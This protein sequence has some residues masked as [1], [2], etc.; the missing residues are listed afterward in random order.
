MKIGSIS[1]VIPTMERPIALERTIRNMLKSSVVPK[2]I[3]VIDQS[4]RQENR[5]ANIELKKIFPSEI[6]FIYE[7][8]T[9]PSLTSARNRGLALATEEIVVYSDDDIDVDMVT[10]E[11]ILIE[12]QDQTIAMIAGLDHE[13]FVSNNFLGYIWGTKSFRKRNRGYVMPSMVGRFPEKISARTETEWAMGF[14]F[15]VRKNLVYSWNIKWDEKLTSYAY[16]EDLDFSYSYYK[17][18][19]KENLC[20]IITPNVIVTHLASK[21]YRVPT[22]KSTY[23]YVVNREYLSY[24]HYKS[25]FSRLSTRWNNYGM[26]L[27]RFIKHQNWMELVKAQITC[28]RIRN[29]LK[30]GVIPKNAYE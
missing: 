17:A 18:A 4:L 23:M 5:K 30:N 9:V 25:C 21:E 14:F 13:M 24:K 26:I 3:I 16:A 20:C 1:V 19:K 27:F 2:Q 29:D 7:Y 28:D 11:N 8:Q 12:M 6:E 10:F 22:K 15:V